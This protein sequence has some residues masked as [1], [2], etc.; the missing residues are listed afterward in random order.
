MPVRVSDKSQLLKQVMVKRD[1][2]ELASLK[3]TAS[4]GNRG[5]LQI[6]VRLAFTGSTL[7]LDPFFLKKICRRN[8][9]CH[10]GKIKTVL[11]N[12]EIENVHHWLKGRISDSVW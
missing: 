12:L 4:F 5:P 8:I 2:G 3:A 10:T 9:K 6:N 11:H 7:T 1:M